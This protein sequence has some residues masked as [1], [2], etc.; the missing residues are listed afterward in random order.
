MTA[1]FPPSTFGVRS[2]RVANHTRFVLTIK[3]RVPFAVQRVS[4]SCAVHRFVIYRFAIDGVDL[5]YSP[6]PMWM[7][8]H[9]QLDVVVR[10]RI[11]IDVF[12]GSS[13]G[14]ARVFGRRCSVY[15]R[16]RRLRS[17]APSQTP[18]LRASFDL[19]F[20]GHKIAPPVDPSAT[21]HFLEGSSPS[22]P[23]C[24]CPAH[25]VGARS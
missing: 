21:I 19:C 23:R 13:V 5:I 11:E 9:F 2:N 6:M 18:T 15:D 12:H 14:R 17:T 1:V 3:M 20:W 4:S 10:D 22:A 16:R 25:H 8:M 7:L 24:I